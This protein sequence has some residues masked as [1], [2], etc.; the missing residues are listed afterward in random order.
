MNPVAS[1]ILIKIQPL[2]KIDYLSLQVILSRNASCP[3]EQDN[4]FQWRQ[5]HNRQEA[6]F[7]VVGRAGSAEMGTT[8]FA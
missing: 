6:H 5:T 4:A 2:L 8:L 7:A 1:T 3:R